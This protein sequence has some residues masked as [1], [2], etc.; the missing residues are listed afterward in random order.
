MNTNTKSHLLGIVLLLVYIAAMMTWAGSPLVDMV[1]Y[2]A[3]GW[4]IGGAI[5][6]FSN[7]VFKQ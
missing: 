4:F 1:M 6:D 7:W 2:C 5:R 3:A